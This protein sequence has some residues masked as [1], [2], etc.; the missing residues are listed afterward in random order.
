[1][2]PKRWA[3]L[4]IGDEHWRPDVTDYY[5]FALTRPEI[6]GLL[7]APRTPRQIRAL[8]EA[9]EKG[10]LHQDEEKHLIDLADLDRGLATLLPDS[11]D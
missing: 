8:A 2:S 4:R 9:L 7:C 10:P 5:R 3:E 6:D 11:D 1:V